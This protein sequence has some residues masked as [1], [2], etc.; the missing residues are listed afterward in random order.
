[1]TAPSASTSKSSSFHLPD[2]R[3]A[4][5]RLRTSRLKYLPPARNY[6]G[7][8][9]CGA[10]GLAR[11]ARCGEHRRKKRKYGS[12]MSSTSS[13]HSITGAFWTVFASFDIWLRDSTTLDPTGL[14]SAQTCRT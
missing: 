7:K 10:E 5:A 14:S 6:R 12:T 13:S 11:R 3:E 4:E 9:A 8:L 1:T 2:G